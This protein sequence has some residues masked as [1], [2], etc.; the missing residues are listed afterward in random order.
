MCG[1]RAGVTRSDGSSN[2]IVLYT[3]YSQTQLMD[4][5]TIIVLFEYL[6]LEIFGARTDQC[7]LRMKCVV[8]ILE[9]LHLNEY[10]LETVPL[11]FEELLLL[12]SE[13]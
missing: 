2:D 6:V 1:C 7:E 11:T 12:L 5:F 4:T 13:M 8:K 3:Q 10:S 9:A